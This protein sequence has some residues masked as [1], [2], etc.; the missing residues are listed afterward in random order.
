MTL[1]DGLH[2][3]QIAAPRGSEPVLRQFYANVLG[4]TEVAKPS[5]LAARGG[6]WFK[7]PGLE[8][9]IGIEEP[10]A[11]ARKAHPGFL[12]SD[13]DALA[14]RLTAAGFEITPA[15]PAEL[16]GYRRFHSHDPVGNRLE[17][18]SPS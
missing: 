9:H 6:A 13:L 8:L 4:L 16:P 14:E 12:V 3:I 1:I 11:P 18:I 10:F 5:L 2:H 17:F 15:D 7:G